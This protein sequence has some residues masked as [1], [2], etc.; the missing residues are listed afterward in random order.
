MEITPNDL[1]NNILF[2]KSLSGFNVTN[3]YKTEII[4]Y[5]DEIDHTAQICESVNTV[6]NINGKLKGYN[7]DIAGFT[8]SMK[9]HQ[10]PMDSKV[11]IIGFGGVAKAILYKLLSFGS[12]LTIAI[13]NYSKDR[14]IKITQFISD[15]FDIKRV[16]IINLDKIN[17]EY[18]LLINATPI[19]CFP[20][21]NELLI[22]DSSILRN[23]QHIFDLIY[24]PSITR[25]MKMGIENGCNVFNGEYMLLWQAIESQKLWLDKEKI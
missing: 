20:N 6:V 23:V 21:S 1:K 14:V 12:D 24:N 3:P 16:N 25:L 8:E 17:G 19:G 13:R 18:D 2:L 4:K 9:F 15:K 5:L 7:T 10:I 11:C 22:K